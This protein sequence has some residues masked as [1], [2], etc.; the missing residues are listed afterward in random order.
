MPNFGYFATPRMVD[1]DEFTVQ[2]QCF[3]SKNS[4]RY[5]LVPT[6]KLPLPQKFILVNIPAAW[7]NDLQKES[8]HD[9]E[10]PP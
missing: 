4:G 8:D 6:E 5:R 1:S 10:K 7:D 2:V 9:P 3:C